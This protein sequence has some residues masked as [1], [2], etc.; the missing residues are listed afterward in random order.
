ME[1]GA[2]FSGVNTNHLRHNPSRNPSAL[3]PSFFSDDK[4]FSFSSVKLRKQ[5]YLALNNVKVES[6]SRCD[7][8]TS[9]TY[10][11]ETSA[12]SDMDWDSL[13]FA[14]IPTDYMYMMKC[15][16]DG[17]FS[18]GELKRF[19][20]IELNPSAGVLNYGQGLF[21]GLKAYKKL[22]GNILLFRPEENALRMRLGAERMC[23]PAPTVEQFV[24]AVKATVL[25]NKRWVPPP[26]KGSL[27][28]RPLLMGSGAVLGLAP[29]PEYTFLIYVSPVG[30][31]FKEG[32]APINLV[33]ET[34]VYRAT[35][36]GTG[37]VKTIGNYA[38][39]CYHFTSLH[40]IWIIFVYLLDDPFSV[41]SLMKILSKQ[42]LLKFLFIYYQI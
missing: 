12:L 38:S 40:L 9:K 1:S 19:G 34:D 35:P 3:L 11:N 28:I 4:K 22:D 24:E 15:S 18:N 17:R 14:L 27:Y 37:G 21:E 6:S 30:N 42:E 25:A 26:G 8:T 7:A 13:G 29:A 32:L 23:M 5:C 10:S 2:V 33:I 36:G 41:D 16:Q 31:Y 20:N 39:V